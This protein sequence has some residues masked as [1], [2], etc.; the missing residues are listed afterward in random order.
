M[1]AALNVVSDFIIFLWPIMPL[2]QIQLPLAQRLHLITVFAFGVFTCVGGI[3]KAVWVQEYFKTWDTTCES[4]IFLRRSQGTK[5]AVHR[6]CVQGH[7][8]IVH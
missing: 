5:K 3:L 7:N 4:S 1:H 8:R 6:G 2:W